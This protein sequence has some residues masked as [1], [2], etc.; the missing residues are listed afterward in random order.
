[1]RS[2]SDT[3]IDLLLIGH[4]LRKGRNDDCTVAMEWQP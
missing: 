4:V 2:C 3:D 1:M